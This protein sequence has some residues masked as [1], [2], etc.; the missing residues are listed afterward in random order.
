ML[1]FVCAGRAL[2]NVDF[3]R[4][5]SVASMPDLPAGP[6][7]SA[8]SSNSRPLWLRIAVAV[9]AVVAFTL[10]RIALR[11]V[12][13]LSVGG[14]FLLFFPAVMIA[15]WFGG[16]WPAAL[17]TVLSTIVAAYLFVSPV[18]SVPLSAFDQHARLFLF[19]LVNLMI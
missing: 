1:G 13:I 10:L 18:V 7:A 3:Q 14:P 17:A 6:V 12:G 8:E 11:E 15:A 4:A 2:P 16:F 5:R 19:V 9:G